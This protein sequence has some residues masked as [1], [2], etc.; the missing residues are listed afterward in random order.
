[1]SDIIT[2]EPNTIINESCVYR[3]KPNAK[4]R[5]C[6]R[7]FFQ[8][9]LNSEGRWS[10]YHYK[11]AKNTTP[12]EKVDNMSFDEQLDKLES[13]L[14]DL[15]SFDKILK[16]IAATLRR[17]DAKPKVATDFVDRVRDRLQELVKSIEE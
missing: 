2:V 13:R 12:P 3:F 7:C 10:V 8:I 1:M 17:Y 9:T 6:D 14:T 5:K 15:T 4:Y 16:F 11:R